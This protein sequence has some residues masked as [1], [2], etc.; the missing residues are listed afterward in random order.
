MPHQMA[1]WG[2]PLAVGIRPKAE[3]GRLQQKST[4]MA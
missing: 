2:T 3:I 4:E 1:N